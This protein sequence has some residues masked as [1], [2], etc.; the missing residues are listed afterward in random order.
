MD[1]RA[2]RMSGES[3]NGLH[4]PAHERLTLFAMLR[5][6]R[7][8][9]PLVVELMHIRAELA[10]VEWA[11]EKERLQRLAVAGTVL[12]LCLL[13]AVVFA[14][15]ALIVGFWDTAYRTWVAAA[16]PVLFVLA[17][18]AAFAAVRRQRARAAERFAGSRE[19]W[20]KDLAW[21]RARL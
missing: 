7:G 19:E 8:A 5:A 2:S 6:M 21:L 18:G 13:L 16:I 10:R 20:A 9:A 14:C 11:Q 3:A 4:E 1:A 17:A 12:G 15:V